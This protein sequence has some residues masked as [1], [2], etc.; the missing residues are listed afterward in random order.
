[1]SEQSEEEQRRRKEIIDAD[2]AALAAQNIGATRSGRLSLRQVQRMTA[3]DEEW[4]AA[5]RACMAEGDDD[6]EEFFPDSPAAV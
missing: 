4:L 6:T 1:M 2:V 5:T 3:L